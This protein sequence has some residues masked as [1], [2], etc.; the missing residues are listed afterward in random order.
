[1]GRKHNKDGSEGLKINVEIAPGN[2][3]KM[4]LFIKAYNSRPDRKTPKIKYIDLLNEALDQFFSA[5]SKSPTAR[6]TAGKKK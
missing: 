2:Q 1:M 6:T 4:D 5:H 3:A